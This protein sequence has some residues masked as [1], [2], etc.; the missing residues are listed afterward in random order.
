KLLRDQFINDTLERARNLQCQ[1]DR[2]RA[3]Y[4]FGQA[5]HPIMDFSSPEHTDENGNPMLWNLSKFWGHGWT[6]SPLFSNEET[7]DLT[8]EIFRSQEKLIRDA[9]QSL[10]DCTCS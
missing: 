3:L 5:I 1:G 9:Y 4:F 10:L 6:E 2:T 8:E 7:G